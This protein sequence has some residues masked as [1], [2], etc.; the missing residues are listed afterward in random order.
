M[1]RQGAK[2]EPM[3][4]VVLIRSASD[5][6]GAFQPRWAQPMANEHSRGSNPGLI[7]WPNRILAAPGGK[8]VLGNQGLVKS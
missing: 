7:S 4:Y 1:N 5:A 8:K 2:G 6:A 3:P